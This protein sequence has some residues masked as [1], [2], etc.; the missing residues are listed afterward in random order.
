MSKLLINGRFLTLPLTGINRFAFE[1]TKRLSKL[2]DCDVIV[3]RDAA[4]P[5]QYDLRGLHIVE[6]G[7]F[8][9]HLWEQ[10]SLWRYAR[11]KKA[12]L[13]SLSG[14][15]PILYR[16]KI[17]TIH[18]LS[19]LANPKWF[20]KSYNFIYGIFTPLAIRTSRKVLTV[21]QFSK[22]EIIKYYNT[23]SDKIQVVYNAL[24]S[25]VQSTSTRKPNN[26]KYVLTVGSLDPRKN[27][28]T[29]IE[30]FSNPILK[31]SELHIVGSSN[32]VFG[33]LNLDQTNLSNIKMLG[34]IS[35]QDLA[36]EYNNATLFVSA[37]LYEGF[38]IPPLEALSNGV[39]IAISDI[40][41]YREVYE[42]AA[43]YF[44]PNNSDT[45]AKIIES[46]LH[47]AV[48]APSVAHI[49]ERYSWEKSAK[50]IHEIIQ[51]L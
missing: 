8:K 5:G 28:K 45:I 36:E 27:L 14:V 25:N 48:S 29:L 35:D 13:L 20:S 17:T 9:S 26:K 12:L 39:P 37:S 34:R 10:W 40:P 21:S 4:I 3:P 22:N 24:A 15:G 7:R 47:N 23:P 33:K 41:V 43:V 38:G 46:Q 49:L 32:R 2:F 42:D 11:R 18:D 19:F 50:K 44:D 31:D 51:S 16:T 30:A 1:L 6:Y